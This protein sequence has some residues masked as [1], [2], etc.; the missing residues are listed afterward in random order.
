MIQYPKISIVTPSYNQG[1]FIE[2]T[3]LSV[4]DQDY[5]DLE[6]L[7]ID[8]G[9]TDNTIDIIRKYSKHLTYWVSEPDRGQSHAINKGFAICTGEIFNW[10]N[11]DDLLLNNA[12]SSVAEAYCSSEAEYKIV[13]GNCIWGVNKD[14]VRYHDKPIFSW[15]LS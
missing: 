1:Q 7:I 12:L 8:G 15:Q 11:S 4:L 3:I 9:S 10:L 14:N 13:V 6:Y 5:P 2:E